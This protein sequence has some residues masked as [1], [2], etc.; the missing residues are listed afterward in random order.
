MQADGEAV[1]GEAAWDAGG[2][3]AD[4]VDRHGVGGETPEPVD[5]AAGDFCR[6]VADGEGGCGHGG[7]EDEVVVLE[8][9]GELRFE[10]VDVTE[11]GDEF[12]AGDLASGF[13]RFEGV[14]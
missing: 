5:I 2:G 4:H 11:R 7:R 10:D 12:R 3:R 8:G 9:V 14:P 13:E 1:G 6:G